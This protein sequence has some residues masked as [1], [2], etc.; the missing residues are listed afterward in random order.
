MSRLFYGMALMPLFRK[1]RT[2]KKYA[3]CFYADDASCCGT[4]E[5]MKLWLKHESLDEIIAIGPKNK[6]YPEPSKSYIVV[7]DKFVEEATRTF[8]NYGFKFLSGKRYLWCF[9]GSDK[10]KKNSLKIKLI[11]G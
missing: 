2:T 9:I 3:Q 7:E 11:N 10:T 5:N 1:L 8:G 6:Y 4:F